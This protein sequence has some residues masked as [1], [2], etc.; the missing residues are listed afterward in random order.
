M[1]LQCQILQNQLEA[2]SLNSPS[3]L[4]PSPTLNFL[5]TNT[6]NGHIFLNLN[7]MFTFLP[8]ITINHN[9]FFFFFFSFFI[10]IFSFIY[11]FYHFLLFIT[12]ITIPKISIQHC[13]NSFHKIKKNSLLPMKDLTFKMLGIGQ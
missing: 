4:K 7:Q 1:N 6:N 8:S 3:L 13:N 2:Q 11:F 5:F 12:F 10:I 9:Y